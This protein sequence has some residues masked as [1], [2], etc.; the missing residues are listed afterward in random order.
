MAPGIVLSSGEIELAA[1]ADPAVDPTLVLQAAVA[2]ARHDCR[3]GR[4]T[5]DRLNDAVEPWPGAWPL[6]ATDDLIALLLEG[7]RSI[8][9][10]EALDQRDLVARLLPE[11]EPV[12][13]KPQRNA[14]HR[15]TVDRHL[16][17]AAA[18][19]AE[20]ADRVSR[21]DLLVLGA[22]L[23]DLGKG[24]PGDHTEVGMELARTIGPR[25][26]LVPSDVD[27]LVA[28]VEHHLLLPDVAMRRDLTDEVTIRQVADTVG[29]V[30]VLDLLHAL[31]EADSLATG[32]S[33]WGSWKEGL[34]TDLVSRVRFVLGGGDVA[35]VTWRLFPDADTLALM[36]RGDIDVSLQSDVITVVC[37]DSAGTFSQIAGVISL[38]G[39]DVVSAQAH[40]D[41]GGMAASQFRIVLPETAINWRAIQKDLGRALA[42]ELALEAR[43][44]DRARTY[45]RRRRTQAE[46]PGPPSVMFDDEA[47]SNSTV[48]VVRAAT[49]VG[50]LHRITKSLSELGLDI[51][52]ATVQTTG[53][54]VVDTFYVRA[55]GGGLITN[56]LHRKEI[57]RAVIH[58]VS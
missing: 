32:P 30:E 41:E 4:G 35:E 11:W 17:E 12:R 48:I 21:P 36:A 47:S 43:L 46:L 54:E 56:E 51:R 6:G 44:D 8:R 3:I 53:M 9:V 55:S 58:A 7:H 13:S 2:A 50:I 22:L 38:H 25:L 14:Y 45:R 27:I 29:S 20:L 31:T 37:P 40:S 39:L 34:V 16:W 18:N 23:H 10:L 24:Y 28:M 57:R 19:A 5:L 33:A 42:H 49:K 52:H 1:D 15:F 26:G